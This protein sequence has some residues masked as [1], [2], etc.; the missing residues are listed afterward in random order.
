MYIDIII[1]TLNDFRISRTF[2]SIKKNN[3]YH[4]LKLIIIDG[5]SSDK[6]ITLLNSNLRQQDTLI[7]ENDNGIFDALNKGILNS[8]SDIVYWLGSDD[9]INPDFD[10]QQVF[11]FYK[12]D[13]NLALLS[14]RTIYFKNN[15]ITRNI[16]FNNPTL[17]KYIYGN[18]F[19][20]FSTFIRGSL[21]RKFQFNLEYK[22]ASD[23]DFFFYFLK[24]KFKCL[25]FPKT[26]VYVEEGGN[27][28]FLP[29][30]LVELFKILK[31]HTNFI[32]AFI[33]ITLRYFFKIISKISYNS[34]KDEFYFKSILLKIKNEK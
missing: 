12:K 5:G 6:Y 30:N 32:I 17:S 18:H 15:K 22:I 8:T 9:F 13:K 7:S 14:Y 34:K 1:P 2:S 4:K 29:N 33:G 3:L 19:P 24:N 10:F 21:C 27:S 16:E 25:S 20:H 23:Y 31:K 28:N 26:L 11:D